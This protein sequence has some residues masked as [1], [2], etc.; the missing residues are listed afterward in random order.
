MIWIYLSKSLFSLEIKLEEFLSSFKK[1]KILHLKRVEFEELKNQLTQVSLFE[2]YSHFIFESYAGDLESLSQ[3]FEK[4]SIS[5]NVLITRVCEHKTLLPQKLIDKLEDKNY[6]LFEPNY[7]SKESYLTKLL[8]RLELPKLP[9]KLLELIKKE[10]LN[11]HIQ[12]KGVLTQLKLVV[13][14]K[15]KLTENLVRNL[16]ESNDVL[17]QLKNKYLFLEWYLSGRIKE[18]FLFLK[19]L[20]QT[21]TSSNELLM[22]FLKC[23]SYSLN[24]HFWNERNDSDTQEFIREFSYNFLIFMEREIFKIKS[25]WATEV[26]Y[27]FWKNR[28]LNRL[29][30]AI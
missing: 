7:S 4:V 8:E 14:S 11:S 29:R 10:A 3:L 30:L 19:S 9:T 25:S 22:E 24:F 26:V 1:E 2:E 12:L 13:D 21:K 6:W 28:P 18:W 23:L 15:E 5:S 16:I 27:F 17:P 20:S